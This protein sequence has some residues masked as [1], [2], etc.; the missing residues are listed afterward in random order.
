M[1]AEQEVRSL[2]VPL[3]NT[4]LL[5]PSAVVAEVAGYTQPAPRDDAP[6]HVLGTIPWRQR[7]L[8]VVC[9]E[10]LVEDRQPD[11]FGPRARII[12]LYGLDSAD[13][14]PFY[15]IMAHGIPRAYMAG[16]NNITAE[17]LGDAEPAWLPVTLDNEGDALL[18]NLDSLQASLV[19]WLQI[20]DSVA[21]D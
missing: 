11:N 1:A 17:P 10:T 9:M 4:R 14:L 13:Q 5:L 7:A 18:P 15:G 3:A 21:L 6:A 16:R 8:P 20:Q 2:L 12:V 19:E